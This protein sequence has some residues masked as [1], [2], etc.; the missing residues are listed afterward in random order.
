MTN[1]YL[2]KVLIDTNNRQKMS[3][4]N[5]VRAIHGWIEQSFPQEIAQGKRLRHLWRIDQIG[6]K[7]YL[8]LFSPDQPDLQKLEKY[9]ITG[10]VKTISYDKL[11]DSIEGHQLL[12]FK[13]T[14]NCV[15]RD[16]KTHKVYPIVG[17]TGQMK[18]IKER[19]TKNG[20][21]L[22]NCS[23]IRNRSV[24]LKHGKHTTY[25]YQAT[26]E[27]VLEVNDL[28]IFK[29]ALVNGIGR[30]KAYGMG[31]LTVMPV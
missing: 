20:F 1:Y 26:F 2:T 29:H 17:N 4:L 16:G 28:N 15:R 8:L 21:M 30:E 31:L 14:V 27:G 23:I 9:G 25:L 7:Q 18:W 13:L 3:D 11:L 12:R 5:N 24:K 10:S 6:T 19:S 22:K